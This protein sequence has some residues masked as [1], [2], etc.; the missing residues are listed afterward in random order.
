METTRTLYW[1]PGVEVIRFRN[2]FALNTNPQL[3]CYTDT[4][5]LGLLLLEPKVLDGCQEWVY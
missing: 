4:I 5:T 3:S 2:T 1:L